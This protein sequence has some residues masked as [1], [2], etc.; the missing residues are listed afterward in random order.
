MRMSEMAVGRNTQEETWHT[1]IVLLWRLYHITWQ[2]MNHEMN[3][4]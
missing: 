3:L 4:Y 1:T 2:L